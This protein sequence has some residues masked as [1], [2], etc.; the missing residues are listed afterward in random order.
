MTITRYDV[1]SKKGFSYLE[2]SLTSQLPT[3]REENHRFSRYFLDTLDWR[4]YAKR[5]YLIAER[6]TDEYVLKLFSLD[7]TDLVTQY[8]CTSLP[9]TVS[10]LGTGK[11]AAILTPILKERALLPHIELNVTQKLFL[12]QD[13]NEKTRAEVS[14]ECE[15]LI[16]SNIDKVQSYCQLSVKEF[17]GYKEKLFI[18]KQRIFKPSNQASIAAWLERSAINT[19]RFITPKVKLKTEMRADEAAKCIL[20]SFLHDIRVNTEVVIADIDV[21]CLHEF[22]VA[23]RR[24]RSFLT[25]VPDIFTKRTLEKFK[26]E[27]SALSDV[28]GPARDL[29]VM[30]LE[31][32]DY[33]G[34]LPDTLQQV[35]FQPLR[36]FIQ[37]KRTD[38]YITLT[39][40]LQSAKFQR[41]LVQWEAFLKAPVPYRTSLVNANLPVNDVANK[42]IWKTYK[43]LLKRGDKITNQSDDEALHELRKLGKK[44]RYL[45]EFF[46]SLHSKRDIKEVIKTLKV[47]QD[48]LGEFQDVHVHQLLFADLQTQMQQTGELSGAENEALNELQKVLRTKHQQCRA[49]FYKTF[50][51]FSDDRHQQIFIKLYK[52]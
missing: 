33:L 19:H 11:L 2:K 42:C 41:L 43:K 29:D 16:A 8:C 26:G 32:D 3:H 51:T 46:S 47:L 35:D 10:T 39:K 1:V 18:N 34:L 49:A 50:A 13:R 15:R 52:S 48:N 22:R 7:Q 45:I 9:T 12:I 38:A 25:Q 17:R 36:M 31:L 6:S 44:L 24:T 37:K 5:F 4:L 21:E 23:V 28:T 30:L 20:Q 14:L 40:Y 27:F